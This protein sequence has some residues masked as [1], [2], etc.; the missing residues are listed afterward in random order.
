VLACVT[1][2]VCITVKSQF[3]M[4]IFIDILSLVTIFSG[5]SQNQNVKDV[6]YFSIH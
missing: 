6:L 1:V 2:G 5:P 3:K 4:S